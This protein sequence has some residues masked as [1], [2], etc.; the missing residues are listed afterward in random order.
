MTNAES[1]SSDR[2]RLRAVLRQLRTE[3]EMTQ[4]QVAAE[5]DWSL[6]KVIR[7]ET[8]AVSVS[9]NDVRGLLNLFTVTDRE[10]IDELVALARKA[11]A[12]P[13]WYP[14]R[15]HFAPGFQSYLDLEAGA[16]ALKFHQP[17]FI[18]GLLQTQRY[19][20]VVN[21]AS[22][23]EPMRQDAIELEIDVRTRRQRVVFERDDPI[24]ITALL[25]EA[26]LRRTFGDTEALREQLAHLERLAAGAHVD[27][28]VVPFT[29][30]VTASHFG[31]FIILE[32]DNDGEG[33]AVYFEGF[34]N[35][36][37]VRSQHQ[38]TAPYV[39]LFRRLESVALPA[40]ESLRLIRDVAR[41]LR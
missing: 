36:Q 30:P 31:T 5:M 17:A 2:R 27:I 32:F 20:R 23:P 40:D 19:A 26:T 18:P 33:P 37:T 8:G 9:T 6:S 38:I 25:E 41:E 1:S 11:R 29:A 28:R 13:W 34:E 16:S 24:E 12:R 15:D 7:I 22:S 4:E 35:A 39:R 3:A 14:Y 21:Q 10:R